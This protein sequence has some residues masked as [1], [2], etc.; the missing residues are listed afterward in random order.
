M[1]LLYAQTT[2]EEGLVV[3]DDTLVFMC[4]KPVTVQPSEVVKVSTGVTLEVEKGFALNISTHPALAD[5][6]CEIFPAL[7]V[8]NSIAGSCR[9][10]IPVR[11]AGRNPV[12][13][14]VGDL[15]A[16]GH[17]AKMEPVDKEESDFSP[18]ETPV[19]RSTPQR[20]NPDFKF[21]IKN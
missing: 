4:V 18:V 10:D 7:V 17:V 21:E 16:C 13:L 2:A 1:K 19:S 8:I 14:M 20:K 15:V 11:N 6:L 9:L 5:K 3:V 12:H